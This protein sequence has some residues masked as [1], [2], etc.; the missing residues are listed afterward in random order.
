MSEFNGAGY[1]VTEPVKK[2]GRSI[3]PGVMKAVIKNVEY[4]ESSQKQTPYIRF[5]HE[6]KLIEGLEDENGNNIGQ[7]AKTTLWLSEGAWDIPNAMWCT[8]ARLTVMADKLGILKQFEEI[9]ASSAEDFVTKVAAIFK[10]KIARWA[11]GGEWS[12][13]ENDKGE[14]IKFIRPNLLT[15]GFVESI[16]EVPNDEDTKLKVDL[17]NPNHVKPLEE[18]DPASLDDA[19]PA[20]SSD[21][22]PW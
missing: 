7:E 19:S 16:T 14:T 20:S 13:F 9:K 6:T 3:K 18:P 10:G 12:S 1:E 8:K 21:D 11:F 2:P 5:T 22:E 17:E 15:F 4:G